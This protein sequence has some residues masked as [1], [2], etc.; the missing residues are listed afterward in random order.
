MFEAIDVT[1]CDILYIDSQIQKNLRDKITSI[2]DLERDL[3]CML[4]ILANNDSSTEQIK[5]KYEADILRKRIKD[6][7]GGFELALYLFRTCNLIAEYRQLLQDTKQ[8][9]FVFCATSISSEKIT[10]KKQVIFDFLRIAQEYIDLENFSL[11]PHVTC[12]NCMSSN[13]KATEEEGIYVCEKCGMQIET[14]EGGPSFK[15]TDR[16]NMA[17]R[18]TYSTRGHFIDA[19]NRLEGKENTTIPPEIFNILKTE[20]KNHQILQSEIEKALLYQFMNEQKLG[21]FYENINYIHASITHISPPDIAV[22]RSELIEMNDQIDEVYQDIKDPDRI[23]TQN[24]DFKLYKLLQLVGYKCK[25]EDFFFLRTF[26]KEREHHD[27]WR[28]IIEELDEKYPHA[29]TSKGL[30]RWRY[31]GTF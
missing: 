22:F 8:N 27:K 18:Y 20:I 7:E 1:T 11:K 17:A 14:G 19:M 28:E 29:K 26:S 15:D 10:R 31:I 16:V 6:L 25:R 3:E 4:W 24:V 5:A 12:K 9:S 13:F 2:P 23:N 30:K 21:A